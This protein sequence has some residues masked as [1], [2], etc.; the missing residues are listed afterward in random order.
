[1][2]LIGRWWMETCPWSENCSAAVW[3]HKKASYVSEECS[4]W[5]ALVCVSLSSLQID[6]VHCGLL[7]TADHNAR[8]NLWLRVD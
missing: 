6:L 8:S 1:M 3:K 2:P 7:H 4:G 5:F